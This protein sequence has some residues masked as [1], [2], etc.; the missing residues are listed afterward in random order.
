[1]F[2][3]YSQF[4]EQLFSRDK[5]ILDIE[6]YIFSLWFELFSQFFDDIVLNMLNFYNFVGDLL[7][8]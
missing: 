6:W 1:M 8:L 7:I 5:R 4:M 2:V 3:C